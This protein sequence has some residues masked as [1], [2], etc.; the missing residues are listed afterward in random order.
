[1]KENPKEILYTFHWGIPLEKIEF[2]NLYNEY[3]NIKAQAP[4]LLNLE[5]VN[6]DD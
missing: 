1:M 3:L 4:K 5:E 2:K 6:L